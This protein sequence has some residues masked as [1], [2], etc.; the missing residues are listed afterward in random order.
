MRRFDLQQSNTAELTSHAGLALIGR[1]LLASKLAERLSA[2][3]LHHGIA[4]ADCVRSYV[5]LLCIGKSD[6]DAIE[7]MRADE[8]F[9]VSLG[10]TD[11]PS[12]P[13]LR[14]RFDAQ[15]DA[16]LPMV[17]EA[18]IEFLAAVGAN[19]TPLVFNFRW[20]THE[21]NRNYV[22]LDIDV[23][24]MDNSKTKK[25]GVAWTYKGHDGY[26][27][28]A[29]YLGAEGWC[30][31][32]ELRIGSQHSQC[33][34]VHFLERVVPRARLLMSA[35][36]RLLVRLD[37]AHDAA[38][39]RAWL[40][41]QDADFIIKWNPRRQDLEAWLK[42]AEKTVGT[43]QEPRPGKRVGIFSVTVEEEFGGCTRKFR[44]VMRVTERTIDKNGALL[45]V[46]HI[47]V[48]GWWVSIGKILLPDAAVIR[49]YNDHGTSE[50]FHSEFKTDLDIE[51]LPSGKFATNDLVMSCAVLTYNILR[52]I[53]QTGLLGDD[54]PVRHAAK[55]RRLRT[56]MQELIYV[57]ARV[58]E[59]GR[60]LG[61]QFARH[62]PAFNSFS[63]VYQK[64]VPG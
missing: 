37:S 42:R 26:A 38:E 14:Q 7:N 46:P 47:T 32:A 20:G 43:W 52:W 39:N 61:L 5:G 57:A 34:F 16:M 23:F 30:L 45:L 2:I 18:S 31:A 63:A 11:V 60:R 41:D 17:D 28:I 53:G 51:R 56:V 33:E 49:V 8:F 15:A 24:P 40:S 10:I 9:P 12:A 44:R 55:R 21:P 29:A 22:P 25:E 59:S 64:L 19:V 13:T 62:C 54:A 27:P 35:S 1:A 3:P 6:F 36:H 50:Q 48:D 58:I 4:H